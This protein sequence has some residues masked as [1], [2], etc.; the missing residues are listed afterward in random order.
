M[1]TIII[2]SLYD[3]LIMN[4]QTSSLLTNPGCTRTTYADSFSLLIIN[5]RHD[6]PFLN[7]CSMSIKFMML[8]N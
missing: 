5:A 2:L 6:F 4:G 8:T 1:K 3:L 7:T